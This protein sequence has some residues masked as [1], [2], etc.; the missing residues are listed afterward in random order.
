[1][2]LHGEALARTHKV[3]TRKTPDL[4]LARLEENEALLDDARAQLTQMVLDD[5]HIT[6][7]GEWLLD[8]YYLIEEQIRLARVHLPKG[9]SRQLPTLGEGPLAG[10]PRV[11]HLAT[12]V[13]AHGDGRVDAGTLSRF[14]AAYQTVTPLKLGELWAIPI[15]LRL[16]LV[17][18]LRRMALAVMRGGADRRLAVDWAAL[19][20]QAAARE[21]KGLVLVLADMVRSS[22]P[23]SG[24]FVAEL[25]RGLHGGGA[26]L[27]MPL[28]W[29]EQWLTQG[30]RSIEQ[31]IHA[32]G[33]QQAA[34]QV[35]IGNSIGSLRTLGSIDWREFVE[36]ESAVE[37]ILRQDP[38]AIY[39][40][41]DFNTRD[42]YR[43]VVERL[44]RFSG[45]EESAVARM[46]LALAQARARVPT[47]TPAKNGD[48]ETHVGFY[49]VDDGLAQLK[50]ALR[51]PGTWSR[52]LAV[53]PRRIPLAVYLLSIALT[54]AFF[55][56]AL[57]FE[58]RVPAP[59]W[60]PL[61][62]I[63]T[64]AIVVFSE[65][66][67]PLVNWTATVL[68]APRRLPRLDFSHGIPADSRTLVVVPSMLD[69][70][71]AADSLVAALE[72]RFLANR[73]PQLHF[74]LLT[75]FT[76]AEQQ[77]LPGDEVL[78]A[79]AARKI[80][81]LNAR[82]VSAHGDRFFLLHRPRRWNASESCWMGHERKRGKLA[83][84]NHLL[85]D[86]D[87]GREGFLRIAGNLDALVD[88]RYVITL[89]TDTQLP[90]DAA[91]E[92]VATLAHPLNHAYFDER[93]GRVTRGYGILQPIVGTSMSGRQISR[94]ARM[95]G[96]E[97]GIDPY[98]RMVSNVYQDLFGEGSFVGKGIY[99][100]DAFER[101]LRGRFPDNRILSHDLLEGCYA[102]AGLVS[103][104]S[105]HE[106]YP[107]RYAADVGRRARWVR[108]DWQLLPWLL[109]WVPLGA[110]GAGDPAAAGGSGR[111]ASDANAADKPGRKTRYE[112]NPLSWLSR[113]KLLDN[114]RRSLVPA[115]AVALFVIGWVLLPDPLMWTVWLACLLLLPI[116]LPVIRDLLAKPSDMGLETHLLQ[117]GQELERGLRR[118]VVELACLPYEA[119][120]TVLAIARSLWRMAISR[121]HLLQW[122]T[123]NEVERNLDRGMRTE[124][125][126]MWFAPTF[127]LAVVVVLWRL[128]AAAL[129]VALPMLSL[130]VL[131]PAIMGWL[132]QPRRQR[133][134]VLSESR[135]A[136]LRALTRRTWAFFEV[137]VRAEDHWLPPDNVQEY[138]TPRLAR[139]TSPT[140][141]GLSLLAN[142]AACDF[143]YL[144][145]AQTMQRCADTLATL[146]SLPRYHG[147]FYNWYDTETLE[148]LPPRYISTVDSGNLA[149][150]LLVLRQ[151]LLALIDAP[152]VDVANTL[153]GLTDTYA[154]LASV[155]ADAGIVDAALQRALLAFQQQLETTRATPPESLPAAA[156]AFDALAQCAAVIASAWTQQDDPASVLPAAHWPQALTAAC[157]AIGDEAR[158][159]ALHAAV[160]AAPGAEAAAGMP[161][162]R[163]LRHAQDP[164]LRARARQRVEELE[165]LAHI[166]G[167]C[168]QMEYGFL[169]DETRHLLAIGYNIDER[170]LDSSYYDLLASEARLCSFVAIAQAQLPQ[171]NWFAL[172]RLLTEVDG[173][174]ALLSW[175]GSMFE[176]L[177]PQLVMPSYADT[178]LDQTAHGAVRAQIRYG[179]RR[180][181]P[182]GMSE[183][184]YNAFDAQ[185]NYQYRAYGV[186]GL[187]L[188]RGLGQD[189]VI[190]PYAS[191]MALMV[192]PVEACRNLQ[193]MTA[194]GFAGPFG[195]YEAIDYTPARVPP[196]TGSC[197]GAFVHGP[198]PGHGLAGVAAPVAR[199]ADAETLRRRCRVPGHLAAAAGAHPAHRPVPS[200]RE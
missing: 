35:S 74:A 39:G 15:M 60:A 131:S 91:R 183:S 122:K 125:R 1:M 109:P 27:T 165:R 7:A 144:T 9:Y 70:T 50:V 96:S 120:F 78:L 45:I 73:D 137:N 186:P 55:V 71:V 83:A 117:V 178:L 140:N 36:T 156:Q 153:D 72:V 179:A 53:P 79:H 127:A 22:P 99:D 191:M 17:E 61:W 2:A 30:G 38:A 63:V 123:S 89:D 69:S 132:G 66:G 98:T 147:H 28:H 19:I 167:Q 174:A 18:N 193:R 170:R 25:M 157:R 130:W 16:A 150:H 6:P 5:V 105:L 199:A 136:F 31:L 126:S 184:G 108:G 88:V 32:D 49:L 161:R 37:R 75:D 168:A 173:E 4:L 159:F 97:P 3:H 40:S 112:R 163:E 162:L 139:R 24:S 152:V 164:T 77:T 177:M 196:G 134:A 192:A 154:V 104:V 172:G 47:P 64:L 102:R 81:A 119:Y 51:A 166:A 171:E 169:Y 93:L 85:R 14:V 56:G 34:D 145:I 46:S 90:R 187:G 12:E 10:M 33:Q 13:I 103:D 182:W 141:I 195:L 26:A 181:V 94:Y 180:G 142:L 129:P 106:D 133:K 121:R 128:N 11:F 114:L 58:M 197:A 44:A 107:S 20:N 175:S 57:L 100:V 138:P 160:S 155:H 80:D 95:Y 176:Y 124:L 23:L 86:R 48:S 82:H 87:R 146:E 200:P 84:L 148:P 111:E 101:S 59:P 65:L 52:G 158:R 185:M 110:G 62:L 115:A 188:K 116:L 198:P 42:S 151:G 54:V 190:A 76:D 41:M 29:I 67:I 135:I 189:L 21:P 43:N 68:V 113:G 194:A 118:A 149:G 143:G 8:N 92:L